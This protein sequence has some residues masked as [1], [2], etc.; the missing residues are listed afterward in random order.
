M[1]NEELDKNDITIDIEK[2]FVKE[3]CR[4][5]ITEKYEKNCPI[6]NN[7]QIYKSLNILRKAIKYNSLCKSCDIFRKTNNI[8]I[9]NHFYGKHHTNET[10]Q[11]I[12]E[13]RKSQTFSEESRKKISLTHKNNKYNLGRKCEDNTKL[14]M[15]LKK[16]GKNNPN[17]GGKY[18]ADSLLRGKCHTE[19]TKQK[20]RESAAKRIQKFGILS[21]NFNPKACQFID[22]LNKE[23]RWNLQHALNG[24]E[25][26]VIGYFLDGYDKDK[27][28][29]FEYD[30]C[31]HRNK[32]QKNK[33]FIR[34]SKIIDFLKPTE[35][36]RYD[37][38]NKVLIKII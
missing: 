11:K 35:F 22:N 4:N 13:K 10:K 19:T 17:Y 3:K 8:G 33:D 12:K 32:K 31:R 37:E 23:R 14:L 34:E 24:G 18:V 16:K 28:I 38:V 1:K 7:I 2:K 36:W 6:C 27:N 25:I 21:R 15:S 29:V 30:E 20:M 9:K 26:V 5:I